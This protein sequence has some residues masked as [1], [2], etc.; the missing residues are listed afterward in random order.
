MDPT[1]WAAWIGASSGLGSFFWNVYTKVTSGPR[2]QVTAFA[3]MVMMP[4]PPNEPRFLKITVQNVGTLPTTL[5]NISFHAYNSRWAKF[6]NRASVNA[7]LNTYQGPQFPYKLEVGGE[8]QALMQQDEKFDGWLHSGK[9]LWC[10]VSH[11]FSEKP[12]QVTISLRGRA[13]SMPARAFSPPSA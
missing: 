1:H 9:S 3:G 13:W 8:W 6:R 7:V 2:L 5:T 10:A 11:S 4:P 12:K